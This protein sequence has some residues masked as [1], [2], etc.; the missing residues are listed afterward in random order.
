MIKRDGL[1]LLFIGMM[2]FISLVGCAKLERNYPQRN[3]YILNVPDEHQNTA[4]VSGTVLEITRFQISPSF[5]G[6]EF[7]YRKGDSSYESD[8]YNQF[9]RA[10]VLVITDEVRE[11]FSES[12]AFKNVVDPTV[13]VN[14]SY[15]LQGNIS[16]LYADYRMPTS[17]KAVMAIQFFLTDE[18]SVNSQIIFQNNYR[19]EVTISTTSPDELVKGWNEALVQILAAL[20]DDINKLDL[21]SGE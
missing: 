11:W 2:L 14:A 6:R 9:F 7:V 20:N 1:L 17:P 21:D 12:G 10:P 13:N 3:Y 16:E 18:T 8:F 19:R 15:A 4:P 5:S